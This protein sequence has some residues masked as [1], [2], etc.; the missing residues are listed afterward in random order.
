MELFR[1]IS[2]TCDD[3]LEEVI[4]T[5]L[6]NIKLSVIRFQEQ[7]EELLIQDSNFNLILFKENFPLNCHPLN[8]IKYL[9]ENYPHI[10]IIFIMTS[11][12]S[13]DIDK[14]TTYLNSKQ[15]YD[16]INDNQFGRDELIS[17][18]FEPK[19][20]TDALNSSRKVSFEDEFKNVTSMEQFALQGFQDNN[21][22]EPIQSIDINYNNNV[23]Y[24]FPSPK[25]VS[26]WSPKG[27]AGVDTLAIQTAYM[28]A[29][30][31][32]IDVC[33][34]DFSDSP[35]MH[36]HFNILDSRKNIES[37]YIQQAAGKLNVYTVDN[38]IINGADTQFK[39]P[40]LHILPGA[41]KR[42]NFYKRMES[43][44]GKSFVGNC[45]E[46]IID[47][48]REKYTVVILILSNNIYNVPTFAGLKKCS[49]INMIL[50]N[51]A[52][53]FYN[54]NRY[55][56][57]EYG[58]FN[59][60]KIDSSKCKIILNKMYVKDEFYIENFVK[61]N[62]L[63]IAAQVSLL[64]EEAFSAYKTANP[65]LFVQNSEIAKYDILSVVNTITYMEFSSEEQIEGDKK[66]KFTLFKRKNHKK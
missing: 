61:I 46:S 27:G 50:E 34:A 1:A 24:S 30:N 41:L 57:P 4:E 2:A 16:I 5:E 7:L 35:N 29:K 6:S 53:S 44:D 40:N 48:L 20:A 9:R 42:I 43:I 39:L 38:Y 31:T 23:K 3:V 62:G 14:Y 59:A 32:K 12:K 10:R 21:E 37:L 28:I 54:A 15:V 18:I 33:I 52:S 65:D 63:P 19:S 49:Q 45:I 36:L 51:D 13:E 17:A 60:S 47:T 56:E 26:F 58:I 25:V 55:L 64:P 22:K 8:F 66:S 11:S